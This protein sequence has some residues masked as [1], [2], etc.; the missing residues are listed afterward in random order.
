MYTKE[1]FGKEL[2]EQLEGNF[3]VVKIARWAENIYS[4][5][6]REISTELSDIIMTLSIMEHGPEFEY[7]RSELELLA[8]S[9]INS[10]EIQDEKRN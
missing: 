5:H 8:Q 3:D 7:T 4:N 2:K 10:K 9:L 6:C 1:R